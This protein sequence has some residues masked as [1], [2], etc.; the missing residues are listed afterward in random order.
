MPERGKARIGVIVPASNI[1][2]EPDFQHLSPPGV[3]CHFVRVGGYEVEDIPDADAMREY[4]AADITE[5]LALLMA[6]RV[7]VIAYGCTSATLS[8][9]PA[10]DRSLRES[11]AARTG[12]PAVTAAAA[13]V[14]S[15]QAAGVSRVGFTSPYV[16]ALNRDAARFLRECGIEVVRSV[17]VG[18][19]L[20]STGQ[21]ELTPEDAFRLGREADHPDAEAVVISCT[22]FR[23]VEAID[24]L[25]RALKKPV[26]TSNQALMDAA[27]GR[28]GLARRVPRRRV[29]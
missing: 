18:E 26:I 17:G 20:S 16:D 9:G 21:G 5:P 4:A 15:L 6:A 13:L 22:D 29:A 2:L 8:H 1:N 12:R 10:Y 24:R 19:T 25:E 28:I 3:T 27:L 11:I 7:H 14:E 23:A